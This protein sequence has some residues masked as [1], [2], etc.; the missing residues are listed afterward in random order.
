MLSIIIPS[1]NNPEWPFLQKTVDDIFDKATGDVEVIVVL[2][3][4]W[5]NPPLKE[6][7]GLTIV[8]NSEVKG[9]RYG[10][11]VGANLA[12]GKYIAK[13]DDHCMFDKGFDEKLAAD[14]DDDWLSVPSR[15]SL[16]GELWKR[17]YG[18]ID[19]LYLTYPFH[20][21]NQ[22]GFGFHGKKWY[23]EKGFTGGYFDR[24]KKLR[25]I[26]IDD[27]VAFQ[28]SFWFMPRKLFFRI[29]EMKDPGYY[30]HQ[31]AQELSFK[32]WTSGGRCIVNKNTWY[33]HL[34]KG[35]RYGRGYHLLKHQMIKSQIHSCDV[36]MNN[37]WEG[38]KKTSKQIIENPRWWPMERW[39]ENWDDPEILKDYPYHMW[40]KAHTIQDSY[41]D[42]FVPY[43]FVL[44]YAKEAK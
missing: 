30:D 36:W 14:C 23:G 8:H 27:I 15:Y 13:C 25:H 7:Q 24:D 21:D 28:G 19:Y 1:R 41:G 17:K 38:Q 35:P 29:G 42:G 9:M 20:C 32:V 40:H 18:P 43:D 12:K 6:R 34:H 3:G 5:P 11:N 10:I 37:R 31:E 2:D 26:L 22:F 44:S 33:A 16:D 4:F 39:P